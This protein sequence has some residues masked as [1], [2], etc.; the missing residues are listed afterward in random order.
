[1]D[2]AGGGIEPPNLAYET[3][4]FP[5][6][7]AVKVDDRKVRVALIIDQTRI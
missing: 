6:L 7:P 5:E 3:K 4:W 2:M 1:M